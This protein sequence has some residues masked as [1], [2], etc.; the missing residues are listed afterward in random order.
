M[1][2]IIIGAV[3]TVAAFAFGWW[4][5]GVY[6]RRTERRRKQKEAQ[7]MLDRIKP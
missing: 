7:Q 1:T 4:L 5:A 6:E 2:Y 3:V